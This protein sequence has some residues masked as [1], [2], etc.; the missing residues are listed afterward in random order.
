MYQ[1]MDAEA[2]LFMQTAALARTV[3]MYALI[4]P[5]GIKVMAQSLKEVDLMQP[6]SM[7][8]PTEATE[9]DAEQRT[10]EQRQQLAKRLSEVMKRFQ[11]EGPELD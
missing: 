3:P 6:E 1:G 2:Q 11:Y 7:L 8:Q 10:I 4:V 9:E 5:D